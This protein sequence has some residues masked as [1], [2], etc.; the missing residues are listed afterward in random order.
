MTEDEGMHV[1]MSGM[2]EATAAPATSTAVPEIAI[3]HLQAR[4]RPPPADRH[5]AATAARKAKDFAEADRIR[6][7]LAARGVIL[8]DLPGRTRWRLA[9]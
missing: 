3:A 1:T 4:M 9:G 6:D 7:E 5:A 8:E 2:S